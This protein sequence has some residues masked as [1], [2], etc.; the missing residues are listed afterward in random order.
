MSRGGS[1][2]IVREAISLYGEEAEQLLKRVSPRTRKLR[3]PRIGWIRVGT[4]EEV[5]LQ[6]GMENLWNGK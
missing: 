1:S 5:R 4:P 2:P 3:R 6:F